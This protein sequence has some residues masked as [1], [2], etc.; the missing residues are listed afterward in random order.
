MHIHQGH[1]FADDQ[2]CKFSGPSVDSDDER[3]AAWGQAEENQSYQDSH[4]VRVDTLRNADG[5]HSI[6]PIQIEQGDGR[7]R[8]AA[9]SQERCAR[10]H[11]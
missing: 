5:R 10:H 3:T 1:H 4:R 8:P 2:G 9:Q 11:P 7:R 6:S